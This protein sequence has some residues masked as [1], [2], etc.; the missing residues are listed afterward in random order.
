MRAPQKEKLVPV[1]DSASRRADDFLFAKPW[2]T[3][4]STDCSKI[5]IGQT[6]KAIP[7]WMQAIEIIFNPRALS[8]RFLSP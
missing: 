3:D 7:E 8:P 1:I 6:T 5:R 2:E 4:D